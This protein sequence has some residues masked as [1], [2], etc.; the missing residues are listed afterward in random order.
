MRGWTMAI[1]VAG[2]VLA[3]A[4]AQ[5]VTIDWADWVA[6]SA[7]GGV[8]TGTIASGATSVGVTYS[9]PQFFA[10]QVSGGGNFYTG[11][12]YTNGDVDNAP[13]TSD[14][15][16]LSLGGTSTITFSQAVVDPVLALVSWN[17]NIVDFGTPI[18]IVSNG[19]GFFGSGTPILNGTGTGFTGNGEVHGIVRILGTHD[20]IT[21]T[22]TSEQWH[23]LTVGIAAVAA[24]E[25]AP[26][27]LLGSALAGLGL[28][29][30]RKA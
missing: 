27:A 24:P 19:S 9:G 14:I 3:S 12:A 20:S 18:E 15:L 5:A 23:G 4:S 25:A 28:L 1:A 7:S 11:N 10:A 21:F 16:E 2:A 30:R 8:A 26:L 22:H 6:A 29:A 13:P 17:G